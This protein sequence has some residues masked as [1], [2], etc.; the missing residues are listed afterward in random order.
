MIKLK[1]VRSLILRSHHNPNDTV[2]LHTESCCYHS[3][4]TTFTYMEVTP[5]LF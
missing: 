1:T 5:Q 2:K 4:Q 3:I